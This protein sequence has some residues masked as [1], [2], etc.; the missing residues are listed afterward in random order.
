MG[1]YENATD[2]ASGRTSKHNTS[3][4]YDGKMRFVAIVTSISNQYSVTMQ[5]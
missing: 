2:E 5:K 4:G 3:V 1:L